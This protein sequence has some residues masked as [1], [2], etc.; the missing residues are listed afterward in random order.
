MR[1]F[2]LFTVSFLWSCG[3]Q[4]PATSADTKVAPTAKPAE[5]AKLSLAQQLKQAKDKHKHLLVF[6]GDRGVWAETL[7]GELLVVFSAVPSAHPSF[8]KDA[9][10]YMA[11]ES[12]EVRRVDLQSGEDALV[13]QLPKLANPCFDDPNPISYIQAYYDVGWDHS[14]GDLCFRINDRNENMASVSL[15][16]RVGLE[17]GKV[18]SSYL[19]AFDECKTPDVV[20]SDG[21]C[22][23]MMSAS[24]DFGQDVTSESLTRAI[25]LMTEREGAPNPQ[26]AEMLSY[27]RASPSGKWVQFSDFE[28]DGDYIYSGL[29]FFNLE[30]GRV[31]ALGSES[32]S[33]V[34]L[35]YVALSR[36]KKAYEPPD[37]IC[38]MPGEG[39]LFWS[40]GADLFV[41]DTCVAGIGV[42]DLNK[43]APARTVEALGVLV[44]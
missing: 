21:I 26:F 7:S 5:P 22:T 31:Y 15:E 14:K 24:A 18:D 10:Y 36:R 39:L 32:E 4:A 37:D 23:G 19:I 35:D 3:G 41:L 34:P 27:G 1:W 16:L 20:E 17:S 9:L 40:P 13:A 12:G 38:M 42:L 43:K 2:I 30:E 8:G 25:A 28:S 44:F 11:S 6:S 29:L 33:L